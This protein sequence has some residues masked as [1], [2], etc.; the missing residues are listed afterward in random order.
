ML[1]RNLTEMECPATICHSSRVLSTCRHISA[2]YCL[3]LSFF[4]V[5]CRPCSCQ[6]KTLRWIMHQVGWHIS[7]I[8]IMLSSWIKGQ[9]T[10]CAAGCS[11]GIA[12]HNHVHRLLVS[13]SAAML[14]TDLLLRAQWG[15]MVSDRLIL[16]LVFGLSHGVHCCVVLVGSPT[17]ATCRRLT[18]LGWSGNSITWCVYVLLTRGHFTLFDRFILSLSLS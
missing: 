1:V 10:R 9:S 17:R 2:F 12:I 7:C 14:L 6:L 16:V 13:V 3:L 11:L 15:F 18:M 4:V 5:V 8:K